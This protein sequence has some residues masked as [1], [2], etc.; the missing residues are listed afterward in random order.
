MAQ[1]GITGDDV[2]EVAADNGIDNTEP[3]A[4]RQ[5]I[6]QIVGILIAILTYKGYVEQNEGQM[7]MAQSDVIVGAILVIATIIGTI[8]GRMRAY[9]PRSAARVAINNAPNPADA[10]LIPPP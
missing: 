9:A 2:I 1:E 3:V 8:A 10:V 5:L 7:L 6:A 4:F